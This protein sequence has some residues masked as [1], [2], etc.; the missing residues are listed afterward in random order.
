[1]NEQ[2][3][4]SCSEARN[5]N[6]SWTTFCVKCVRECSPHTYT[7]ARAHPQH[8]HTPLKCMVHVICSQHVQSPVSNR[9]CACVRARV[10][11]QKGE[12][13]YSP[14]PLFLSDLHIFCVLCA[15]LKNICSCLY[16][17][18]GTLSSHVY[19]H[20]CLCSCWAPHNF[21]QS[22]VHDLAQLYTFFLVSVLRVLTVSIQTFGKTNFLVCTSG[23]N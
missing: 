6:M 19:V 5:W 4:C 3:T 7:H 1:M 20:V 14:C 16:I 21:Q 12:T 8:T 9:M 22:V 10:C 23:R 2:P 17:T 18:G 15:N 11:R 13:M